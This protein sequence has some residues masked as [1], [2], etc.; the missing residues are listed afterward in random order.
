VASG[1]FGRYAAFLL[2]PG[3]REFEELGDDEGGRYPL[4]FLAFLR[5]GGA[6]GFWR[7]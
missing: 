2:F 6:S 7:D 1:P 4:G 3:G 5:T